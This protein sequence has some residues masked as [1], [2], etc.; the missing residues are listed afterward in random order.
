MSIKVIKHTAELD[1]KFRTGH[2]FPEDPE[3][4]VNQMLLNSNGRAVRLAVLKF[5]M[6]DDE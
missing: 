2:M 3:N 1:F 5:K 6:S 4:T